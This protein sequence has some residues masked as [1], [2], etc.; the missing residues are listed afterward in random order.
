MTLTASKDTDTHEKTVSQ[1]HLTA[2]EHLEIAAKAHKEAAKLHD[3]GDHKA[4]EQQAQ[5][6]RDH[7]AKAGEH[8]NEVSKKSASA[9]T[10]KK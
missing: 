5:L 2:A 9:S 8:V 7:T 3:T 6:A 4:A 1:H 10:H